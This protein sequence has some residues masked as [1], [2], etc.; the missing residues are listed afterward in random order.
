[1]GNKTTA[2]AMATEIGV[3]VVPGTE[4][5]MSSAE[6]AHAF[7][8]DAGFP[9]I[10]KAA[11]G[12]GGRGMRVVRSGEATQM[13]SPESRVA[14]TQPVGPHQRWCSGRAERLLASANVVFQVSSVEAQFWLGWLV[15][16]GGCCSMRGHKLWCMPDSPVGTAVGRRSAG[17]LPAFTSLIRLLSQQ[18]R[19]VGDTPP[20]LA[21]SRSPA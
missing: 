16:R 9:I 11:F 6:E 18:R 3:P 21:N 17:P 8:A 19:S 12:G 4:T 1:M 2:R 20:C 5:A 7:A 15:S 13:S 10:L 14:A